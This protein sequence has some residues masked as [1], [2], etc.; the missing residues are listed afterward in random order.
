MDGL[1]LA[2][3]SSSTRLHVRALGLGIVVGEE[4]EGLGMLGLHSQANIADAL[5]HMVGREDPRLPVSGSSTKIEEPG[6][7]PLV[8]NSTGGH[9]ST[10]VGPRCGEYRPTFKY[11]VSHLL[12]P[13]RQATETES[14][15]SP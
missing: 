5:A 6:V 2:R 4:L 15:S 7:R 8:S 10:S 3:L 13:F 14:P 1:V 9:A 12:G 11:R